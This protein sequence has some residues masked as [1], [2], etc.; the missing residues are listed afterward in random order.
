MRLSVEEANTCLEAWPE[1]TAGKSAKEKAIVA[2]C[3][4][5]AF[6]K[7]FVASGGE[8]ARFYPICALAESF[9][10]LG[11]LR[12]LNWWKRLRWHLVARAL[13]K[14]RHTFGDR[15]GVNDFLMVKWF[16]SRDPA[17]ASELLDR[18]GHAD[19]QIAISCK[20][21][22]TSVAGRCPPLAEQLRWT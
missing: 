7:Q 17:V 5:H 13:R 3:I 10:E 18:C 19:P 20:W 8:M 22:L 14:K 9:D 16:I 6:G 12:E 21:M 15:P 1:A 11:L 4:L 2:D